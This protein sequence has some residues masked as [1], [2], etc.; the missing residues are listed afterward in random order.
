MDRKNSHCDDSA[1]VLVMVEDATEDLSQDLLHWLQDTRWKAHLFIAGMTA[2]QTVLRDM[3]QVAD[4]VVDREK[5]GLFSSELTAWLRRRNATVTFPAD[6]DVDIVPIVS[7]SEHLLA[8][9]ER[10]EELL[11]SSSFGDVVDRTAFRFSIVHVKSSIAASRV[12]L[13]SCSRWP[14]T[15]KI[16]HAAE[17]LDLDKTPEII[18]SHETIQ[19]VLRNAIRTQADALR[20][21]N[22][23]KPESQVA[24]IYLS[25]T[26][27]APAVQKALVELTEAFGWTLTP[28]SVPLRGSFFRRFRMAAINLFTSAPAKEIAE[29]IRRGVELATIHSQQADNDSKQAEAVAN[30]LQALEGTEQGVLLVGSVLILKDGGKVS[31]RT[32]TQRQLAFLER[33]QVSV[34][35]PSAVLVALDECARSL[36]EEAVIPAAGSYYGVTVVVPPAELTDGDPPAA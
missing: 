4:V 13:D 3:S 5:L 14:V 28:D 26:E 15:L 29:E 17:S 12:E 36:S 27:A 32:L 24:A 9:A 22:S 34:T 16:V 19:L 18:T 30:L 33:H 23:D 10:V 25:N 35:D 11:R 31:V 20:S 21:A 2:A 1:D 6:A 8:I 7:S